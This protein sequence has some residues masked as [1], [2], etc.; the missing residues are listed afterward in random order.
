MAHRV[1]RVQ[2]QLESILGLEWLP[3]PQDRIQGVTWGSVPLVWNTPRFGVKESLVSDRP[4]GGWQVTIAEALQEEPDHV[5]SWVIWRES[6]LTFLLPHLRHIPEVADLGLYAGL[7]HGNFS[8]NQDAELKVL[9]QHVSVPQH[10]VHYIYDAPY[11]FPLFDQVVDGGFLTRV[12]TWLNGFRTSA[13]APLTSTTYTAALEQWMLETHIPLTVNE[14]RILSVLAR[15]THF[16]QTELAQQLDMLPSA[17][18]PALTKLAQR[19]I[20][21]LY[22]FTNLPKIGLIPFEVLLR[23]SNSKKRSKWID[24]LSTARY[25]YSITTMQQDWI[26]GRLL[27]PFDRVNDLQQWV[28]DL[29]TNEEITLVSLFKVTELVD[30]WNFGSYMPGVGW[31]DDFSLILEQT[32]SLLYNLKSKPIEKFISKYT[33]DYDTARE[34][35]FE[36]RVE[37]F[38]YFRRAI[39]IVFT[40]DRISPQLSQE[41]RNAGLSD[42]AYRRRVQKL[43]E[44]D[45]STIGRLWLLHIGLDTVIQLLLFE[46]IETVTSFIQA[47]R[48]FPY[49]TGSIYE[50]GNGRLRV[51]VPNLQAVEVLSFLQK[52][53]IDLEMGVLIEAQPFWK[54][55]TGLQDPVKESNYDFNVGTWKWDEASLP[56]I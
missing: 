14:V 55:V 31:V 11:G 34:N 10:H 52:L 36:L 51:F 38:I 50:R 56:K 47:M 2:A 43:E 45:I 39:D 8:S 46:P 12:V 54:A 18:S 29:S 25:A 53:A 30:Y 44:Q 40:T 42:S 24:L 48:T 20:L 15:T 23:I 33:Y 17:L 26:L 27:I 19:H 37:D 6:F 32:R 16:K 49:I 9:W 1:R 28:E 35:I 5:L 22:N 21:R 13:V 3:R 7:K 4:R 41:I